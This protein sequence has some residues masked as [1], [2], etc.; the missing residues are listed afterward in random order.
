MTRWT[1]VLRMFQRGPTSTLTIY[2]TF[3][4]A[5]HSWKPRRSL[6]HPMRSRIQAEEPILIKEGGDS[7]VQAGNSF[8]LN[9]WCGS[10]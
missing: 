3:M 8:G 2:T 7:G 6:D 4:E 9:V 1:E 5:R 10:H